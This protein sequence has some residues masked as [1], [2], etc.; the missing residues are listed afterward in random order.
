[1]SS[2]I[3][4]YNYITYTIVLQIFLKLFRM[5]CGKCWRS[6]QVIITILV[7]LLY[8]AAKGNEEFYLLMRTE[9]TETGQDVPAGRNDLEL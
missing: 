4:P 5:N 2:I 7:I 3:S 8:Y 6:A 1:M 9:S